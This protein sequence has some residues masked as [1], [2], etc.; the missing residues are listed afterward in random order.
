NNKDLGHVTNYTAVADF[1][2]DA[3]IYVRIIPYNKAGD[4]TGCS[5]EHFTTEKLIDIP[6]CTQLITPLNNATDVPISSAIQW[7]AVATATGYRISIGT[8]SGGTDI[9]NSKDIGNVTSYTP[10]AHFPEDATIYVRIIPYNKAGDATGCSEEHF[11]TE[12]LIDIPGCTQLI[13]PLNNAT[14]VPI[15]STIQWDAVA[16]A[17]GYRISIGTSSGG[18]G[19]VNS[20]DLGNVTSYT[21]V[22]DFPEGATIYVR[23]IAYNEAGDA[24]GCLEEQFTTEALLKIPGCAQLISALNNATDVALETKLQSTAVPTATGY[25]ISIGTSSGGTDIV[26]AEDILI[27]YTTPSV[28]DFPEG[29]TIYVRIIAYNETGDATGCSEEQFTTEALL[30]IPGCT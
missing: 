28:S 11:S 10:V 8:S 24:T 19:I 25:R 30:N 3:T 6:Q 2:E 13:T 17:T 4:A 1:Q 5:E 23:I 15:S 18:T 26:N 9:V 20:K 14:D 29:A 16:T 7:D 22:A 21:P 27:P 12:K